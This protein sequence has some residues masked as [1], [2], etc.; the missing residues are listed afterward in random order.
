MNQLIIYIEVHK[1]RPFNFE[2]KVLSHIKKKYPDNT[3]LDLDNFSS[4]ELFKH[5]LD[6]CEHEHKIKLII[7]SKESH[8]PLGPVLNFINKSLRINNI[9]I[10][11]HLI[12]KNQIAEKMLTRTKTLKT[13]TIVDFLKLEEL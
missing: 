1:E 10:T 6:A 9:L 11:S 7:H 8:T 12:G 2:N 3:L 5:T 4:P 13:H